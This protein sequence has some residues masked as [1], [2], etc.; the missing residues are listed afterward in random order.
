MKTSPPAA[1][2]SRAVSS[3]TPEVPPVMTL[4]LPDADWS[5]MGLLLCVSE[6]SDG[7]ERFVGTQGLSWHP[8]EE[9][10]YSDRPAFPSPAPW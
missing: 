6:R 3:P 4:C 1:T 8:S 2:M 7:L 10:C 9:V 5:G